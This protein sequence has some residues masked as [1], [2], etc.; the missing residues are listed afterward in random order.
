MGLM[1]S[2]LMLG[3]LWL[4]LSL[5]VLIIIGQLWRR[6]MGAILVS[7]TF[8][9]ALVVVLDL[10]AP[11]PIIAHPAPQPPPSTPSILSQPS[12]SASSSSSTSAAPKP[13]NA[14]PDKPTTEAQNHKEA[15]KRTTPPIA[16]AAE[17]QLPTAVQLSDNA[18]WDSHDD[19]VNGKIQAS[20][21]AQIDS[22]GMELNQPYV[23]DYAAIAAQMDIY[24]KEAEEEQAGRGQWNSIETY[25]YLLNKLNRD[26]TAR[27][28]ISS[29]RLAQ[30]LE[31]KQKVLEE[32]RDWAKSKEQ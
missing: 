7:C 32:I 1:Y 15:R 14:S 4:M 22:K 2:R 19:A 11:K 13:A 17:P 12:P 9:F 20:G 6:K 24:I 25:G 5:A 3:G 29:F 28:W 30:D 26:A 18:H 8:A 31:G 10:I 27:T 21:H 23:P 16:P